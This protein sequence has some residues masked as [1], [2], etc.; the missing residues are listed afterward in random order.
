VLV[1]IVLLG[2]ADEVGEDLFLALDDGV[3]SA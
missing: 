2:Y 3:L 1:E